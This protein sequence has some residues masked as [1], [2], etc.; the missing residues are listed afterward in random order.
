MN[1]SLWPTMDHSFFISPSLTALQPHRVLPASLSHQDNPRTF[2]RADVRLCLQNF[3]WLVF[4]VIHTF[5]QLALSQRQ[6]CRPPNTNLK[7]LPSCH[8]P[9]PHHSTSICS[10]P[11][12]LFPSLFTGFSS[13][14]GKRHHGTSIC[15]PQAGAP[16]PKRDSGIAPSHCLCSLNHN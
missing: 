9:A 4:L 6:L 5:A 10:F 15:F 14:E 1:S 13:L 3:V 7:N 12:F 16:A 2:A 11:L 8:P